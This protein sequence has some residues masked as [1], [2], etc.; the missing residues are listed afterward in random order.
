MILTRQR[1]L[2]GAIHHFA[3]NPDRLQ[4][5]KWMFL[6]KKE[7]ELRKLDTF[8]DFLPY[9]YGP[10]SF[11][12]YRDLE[13]FQRKGI[14]LEDNEG[15]RVGDQQEINVLLAPLKRTFL[16]ALN[17]T[18]SKYCEMR[19]RKLIDYTYDK[20]PWYASKSTLNVGN[21]YATRSAQTA[22]YTAGYEGRSIDKFF[23]RLLETGIVRLLDVRS[24]AY[25]R[26]YGFTG[27]TL[28]RIAEKVGIEY[29]HMPQLGIPPTERRNL[30]TWED[31]QEVLNWYDN[32]VIP[33]SP[34][35]LSVVAES[36]S[37]APT[38]VMCYERDPE[39]CHRG[40]L[41]KAISKQT[42]LPVIHI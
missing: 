42:G 2:L 8:Y 9:K 10:F 20:Y 12:L 1:L 16:D 29:I 14:A 23:N 4:L 13:M 26:K 5:V 40:R 38:A 15:W 33:A 7:T 41:A 27:H 30:K 36:I 11:T 34:E 22:V 6:A 35:H 19:P 37:A 24:H 32:T 3:G 17:Q 18:V 39:Y 28:R 21:G 31:Y 25:S